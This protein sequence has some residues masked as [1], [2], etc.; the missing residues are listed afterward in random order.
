MLDIN[1][2]TPA[3]DASSGGVDLSLS[4]DTPLGKTV[5]TFRAAD[6]DQG[7]NGRLTYALG[8]GS[9]GVRTVFSLNSDSGDLVLIG[10]LDR[11]TRDRM[12]FVVTA[13]DGGG[14]PKSGSVQVRVQVTD[15]ND[16]APVFPSSA[17]LATVKEN[18]VVGTK[19]F[20]VEAT[21][22]DLGDNGKVTY[23]LVDEAPEF[24][25]DPATGELFTAQPLDRETVS[26]YE[27]TVVAEDGG[28]L[29]TRKRLT[30]V[31]EDDNDHA[32]VVE[33]LTTAV[34]TF[35]AWDAS[36]SSGN[37]QTSPYLFL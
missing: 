1:D 35:P 9:A 2:L 7:V 13:T 26:E 12:D 36:L 4:E 30:V 15:V 24:R 14:Q 31:V 11:E 5:Y 22:L 16:N 19:F 34:L 27:V 10:G 37:T 8:K 3:F 20:R 23:S 25:L 33:S 21:D 29:A 18:V 28:G 6:A 17:L 32:P